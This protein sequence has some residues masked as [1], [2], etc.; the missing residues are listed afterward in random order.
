MADTCAN[1]KFAHQ[2]GDTLYCRRNPPVPQFVPQPGPNGGVVL[3][4]RSTFPPV[5]ATMCCGEHRKGLVLATPTDERVFAD[6]E[7]RA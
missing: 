6:A 5:V 4:I 1:C 7:G 2:G 3:G